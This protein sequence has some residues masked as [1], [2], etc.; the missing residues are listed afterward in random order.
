[1]AHD[2]LVLQ[3]QDLLQRAPRRLQVAQLVDA[4]QE[5]KVDRVGLQVLELPVHRG[6]DGVAVQRPAVG[7]GA[8][9]RAEVELQAHLLPPAGERAAQRRKER[10]V[11]GGKVHVVDAAFDRKVQRLCDLLLACAAKGAR[12]QAQDA[13]LLPAV[14]E[15]AVLHRA[16]S[17][18]FFGTQPSFAAK[19]AMASEILMPWGQTASQLRQPRQ[20]CGRL[21]S[22]TAI[23]AMGAM[24]PPSV[25][26]CSL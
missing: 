6:A 12:A 4:V 3:A 15:L 20:A 24:K 11:R 8:V 2:A 23:S 7:A 18:L 26:A 17:S 16:E 22:G 1:M 25:K 14:G 19:S 21:S 10:A 13:D 5:P 9:V